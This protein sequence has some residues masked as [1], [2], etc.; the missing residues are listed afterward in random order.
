VIFKGK[1]DQ[2]QADLMAALRVAALRAITRR[3]HP[4]GSRADINPHTADVSAYALSSMLTFDTRGEQVSESLSR[5]VSMIAT[6][7]QERFEARRNWLA[8][9]LDRL[10]HAE[11]GR[12]VSC[13]EYGA[14]PPPDGF[15][16]GSDRTGRR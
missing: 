9:E 7:K 14:P 8:W 5:A 16:L 13:L 12:M 2:M 15:P 3:E 11:A 10:G 1:Q 4:D 6:G